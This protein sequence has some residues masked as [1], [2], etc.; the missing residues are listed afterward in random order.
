MRA[1]VFV[2]LVASGSLLPWDHCVGAVRGTR[3]QCR[4]QC[5]TAIVERCSQSSRRAF[6]KCRNSILRYCRRFSLDSCVLTPS[7]VIPTGSTAPAVTTTTPTTSSTTTTL[8]HGLSALL[9]RWAFTYTIVST[10]TDHYD[11]TT[12]QRST[13]GTFDVA[14]GTN[15]DVG[16][17]VIAGRVQEVAPGSPVPQEF[18]LLDP[19]GASLCEFFVFDLV[20]VSTAEGEAF[21]LD[22]NCENQIGA[23]R[24]FTG[25]RH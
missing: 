25:S 2:L 8:P 22:G 12:I 14:V 5:S 16:N 3:T 9:G 20:G 19:E 4:Q 7:T 10:Y 18:A 13:D 15:T 24:A 6:R 11:L 23:M 21:F 1:A 17:Q